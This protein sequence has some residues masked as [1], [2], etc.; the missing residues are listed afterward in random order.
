MLIDFKLRFLV[1]MKW[2]RSRVCRI[3]RGQVDSMM[4]IAIVSTALSAS[5]EERDSTLT[6]VVQAYTALQQELRSYE[7]EFTARMQET[8]PGYPGLDPPISG[9][10]VFRS[11][12]DPVR[13]EFFSKTTR[14]D[15]S[16]ATQP[17]MLQKL[18][19]GI[20]YLEPVGIREDGTAGTL[21]F[22]DNPDALNDRYPTDYGSHGALFGHLGPNISI[23]DLFGEQPGIFSLMGS[24]LGGILVRGDTEYGQLKVWI[25]PGT[26]LIQQATLNATRGDQGSRGVLPK[27]HSVPVEW[28]DSG[29]VTEFGGNWRLEIDYQSDAVGSTLPIEAKTSYTLDYDIGKQSFEVQARMTSWS[30]DENDFPKDAFTL[31]NVPIG[32]SAF[33]FDHPQLAYVWNGE[34]AIPVTNADVL[35]E[36][37]QIGMVQHQGEIRG[38]SLKPPLHSRW[39][40]WPAAIIGLVG[41]GVG[42]VLLRRRK[43]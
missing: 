43:A 33:H 19:N 13:F 25:D 32:R 40:F 39:W 26:H 27:R 21:Y 3:G 9:N 7:T 23:V 14:V 2:L 34:A 10:A 36:I 18:W 30:F 42:G 22:S 6:D 37:D 4:L 15:R 8:L 1:S 24:D 35:A 17:S 20:Q 28:V 31:R 12:L 38:A 29:A 16:G 11:S 5:G 41:V